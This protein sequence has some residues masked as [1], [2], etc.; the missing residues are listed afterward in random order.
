MGEVRAGPTNQLLVLRF[1][2]LFLLP[3]TLTAHPFHPCLPPNRFLLPPHSFAMRFFRLSVVRCPSVCPPVFVLS[4][5]HSSVV[6]P[7]VLSSAYLPCIVRPCCRR[8][9][10]RPLPAPLYVARLSL[11]P[12]FV[13]SRPFP[14]VCPVCRFYL[15]PGERGR[16]PGDEHRVRVVAHR[17]P[18]GLRQG[19]GVRRRLHRTAG[20]RGQGER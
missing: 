19:T 3:P 10:I 13:H 1:N 2:Q 8:P 4:S 11:R 18:L 20:P 5:V 16:F 6:R 7:F 9:S 17:G 12:S 15:R 14:S